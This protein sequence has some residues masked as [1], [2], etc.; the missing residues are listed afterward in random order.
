MNASKKAVFA[1]VGHAKL[2]KRGKLSSSYREGFIHGYLGAALPTEESLEKASAETGIP[3]N[4]VKAF[5]LCKAAGPLGLAL[6]IGLGTYGLTKIPALFRRALSG[7]SLGGSLGEGPDLSA[8]GGYGPK[9]ST[10]FSRIAERM[11][12]LNAQSQERQ[13]KLRWA[14][15]PMGGGAPFIA[16]PSA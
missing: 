3:K 11:A 7:S 4:T 8:Y 6:G 15:N 12:L 10:E 2:A 13:R 9:D 16:G 14:M 1:L 5:V